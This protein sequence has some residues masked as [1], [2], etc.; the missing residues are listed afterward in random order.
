MPFV[1]MIRSTAIG[2]LILECNAEI[3]ETRNVRNGG[4]SVSTVIVK[5]HTVVEPGVEAF[6]TVP[7][8]SRL[9]TVFCSVLNAKLVPTVSSEPPA[10]LTTLES[11]WAGTFTTN[12]QRYVTFAEY[13]IVD[14]AA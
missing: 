7:H 9:V 10:G 4:G 2:E 13:G 5:L 11:V 8:Q 3:D 14:A 6:T 12:R 1:R